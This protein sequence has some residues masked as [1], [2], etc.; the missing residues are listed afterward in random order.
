M[1]VT[2]NVTVLR[3]MVTLRVCTHL[4]RVLLVTSAGGNKYISLNIMQQCVNITP[5][6]LLQV[7]IKNVTNLSRKCMAIT[8]Y[9]IV[10]IFVSSYTAS[11]PWL[12]L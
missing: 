9:L 1:L 4:E 11:N 10:H 2:R 7:T 6:H 5:L 12:T 3:Y 8:T